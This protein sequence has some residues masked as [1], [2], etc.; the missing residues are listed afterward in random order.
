MCLHK[1]S[2]CAIQGGGGRLAEVLQR[3]N[4]QERQG[5][6]DRA[7]VTELAHVTAGL[8]GP[9]TQEE[10]MLQ[11]ELKGIWRRVSSPSSRDLR[12]VS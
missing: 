6:G 5:Q 1:W 9:E 8:A 11:L 12:L 7:E 10:L 3:N 2:G 4:G